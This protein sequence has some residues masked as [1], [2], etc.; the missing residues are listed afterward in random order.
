ML[1]DFKN[2][3]QLEAWLGKQPP[4]VAIVLAA[5][6]A[7]RVLPVAQTAKHAGFTGGLGFPGFRATVFSWVAAKYPAQRTEFAAAATTA[8]AAAVAAAA[9]VVVALATA[10]A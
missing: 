2:R 10:D 7:L 5:R 6:A 1:A 4:D 8:Y 3:S 9:A